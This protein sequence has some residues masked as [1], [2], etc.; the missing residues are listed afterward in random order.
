MVLGPRH[1][2]K[3]VSL[4]RIDHFLTQPVSDFG[5]LDLQ[6]LECLLPSAWSNQMI[7]IIDAPSAKPWVCDH[8]RS[9]LP[10][11]FGPTSAIP[12]FPEHFRINPWRKAP[13]NLRPKNSIS[14]CLK[15]MCSSSLGKLVA[16]SP[17]TM[18]YR[19]PETAPCLCKS[20]IFT[21]VASPNSNLALEYPHVYF[22]FPT[23][24][25]FCLPNWLLGFLTRW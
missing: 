14:S 11:L 25:L 1:S 22:C 24:N 2:K 15:P 17:P 13:S 4:W 6:A 21:K 5:G 3:R 8:D 12:K 16:P 7:Y 10:N 19:S 18:T 9:S 20:G 23:K